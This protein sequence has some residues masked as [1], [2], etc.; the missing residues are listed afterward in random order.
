MQYDY[1]NNADMKAQANPKFPKCFI[2]CMRD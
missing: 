1:N 2:D